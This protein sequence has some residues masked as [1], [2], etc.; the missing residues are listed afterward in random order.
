MAVD[1]VTAKV[2]AKTAVS[3][4]ADERAR[5]VAITL[6]LIP[7]LCILIVLSSPFAI[8]FARVDGSGL[9][10]M[11]VLQS[12]QDEFKGRIE[13][14]IQDASVDE[15][16]VTYLGSE[17]NTFID[18]RMDV[19]YVYAIQHNM[20][21]E[22][23]MQM[24][25]LTPDHLQKLEKI[26]QKMN[27]IEVTKKTE[28]KDIQ[29]EM[30]N[31]ENEV[32]KETKTVT[33]EIKMIHVNS[34]TAEEGARSY[35]FNTQQRGVLSEMQASGMGAMLMQD[36]TR[37]TLSFEE[38]Q[39]IQELLPEDLAMER[40][41][42]VNQASS[43]VGQVS[44]FWG[45]KSTSKGWDSR[46][47]QDTE[48]TSPGSSTSGTIRPYGLDCSGY[49]AWVFINAGIP[50]ESIENT[51][52]LGTTKQWN[53]STSITK[54]EVQPGD[55]AFL[56]IPGTRKVNHVGI[57]V[58]MDS[59]KNIQ[60]VHCSAGAKGVSIGSAEDIGLTYFRRPAVLINH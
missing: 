8:F 31:A 52:G 29:V 51:L 49:V 24:S 20:A 39:A 55:L 27:R 60:I 54:G 40:R 47:G 59:Q 4:V 21:K 42:I 28:S 14:E 33:K 25:V 10:V 23:S 9:S 56:A 58:S 15:V 44:Y 18:N 57:V 32:I 1:P 16:Q 26:Y 46:W 34:L 6:G 38:I 35:R 41:I 22:A 43:L 37:M 7:V 30:V 48:V 36:N 11:E 2:I 12:Y 53:Q 45:G 3:L 5:K 50:A 19:V 17:D 13:E